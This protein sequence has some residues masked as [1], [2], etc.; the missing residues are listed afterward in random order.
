VAV[1]KEVDV[2]E[3]KAIS[4]RGGGELSRLT[5]QRLL[6]IVVEIVNGKVSS[7]WEI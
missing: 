4:S 5:I 7:E 3:T 2:N 6:M 1:R